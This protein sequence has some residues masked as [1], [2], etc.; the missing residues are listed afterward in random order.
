MGV[1]VVRRTR[2][3][4]MTRPP[5]SRP[6]WPRQKPAFSLRLPTGHRVQLHEGATLT[7]E[8]FFGCVAS[9]DGTFAE[10][11]RNPN[12]A[13]VLGLTNL[14]SQPWSASPSSGS[15]KRVD[16]GRSIRLAGGTNIDF[17]LMVGVISD[18]A[19]GPTLNLASGRT[20]PL[21]A[22]VRLSM[23]G[24]LGVADGAAQ[25]PVAHVASHPGKPGVLGLKNLTAQ[26]WAA[27]LTDGSQR[28]VDSGKSIT[29]AAGTRINFG[30]VEGTIER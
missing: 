1:R 8:E 9:R 21:G 14:S 6:L 23:Q 27:V 16:P 5:F 29:L 28:R 7:T 30:V 26:P 25:R 15:P 24:L 19:A 10:V 3:T 22:G 2:R 12:D 13:R 17:G 4:A 11:R 20:I 18:G